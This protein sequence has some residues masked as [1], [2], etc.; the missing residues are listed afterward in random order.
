MK[1]L[2]IQTIEHKGIK[3]SFLIDYDDKTISLVQ[4]NGKA[5]VKKPY[6]FNERNLNYMKK[7]R[8]VLDALQIAITVAQGLLTEHIDR[9]GELH[10]DTD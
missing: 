8:E 9:Q 1:H 2:E 3:V 7:W 5:W 4:R 10:D 6:V